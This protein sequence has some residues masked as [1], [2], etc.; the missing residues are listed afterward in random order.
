[1]TFT[2]TSNSTKIMIAMKL[3]S[4]S[5]VRRHTHGKAAARRQHETMKIGL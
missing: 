4:A 3:G 2:K 1:M 5:I